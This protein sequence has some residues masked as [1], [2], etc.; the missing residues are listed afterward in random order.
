[1]AKDYRSV[2]RSDTEQGEPENRD[3]GRQ[4]QPITV[5]AQQGHG[6]G[7]HRGEEDELNGYSGIGPGEQ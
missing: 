1:M 7:G 4:N 3:A 6:G 2:Q 5:P